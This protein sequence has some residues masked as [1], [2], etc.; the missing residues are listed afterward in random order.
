MVAGAQP[1]QYA[2]PEWVRRMIAG[3]TWWIG[4]GSPQESIWH[5]SVMSV[6]NQYDKQRNIQEYWAR[7]RNN[8]GRTG[9]VSP[10]WDSRVG[11]GI[12]G[13]AVARKKIDFFPDTTVVGPLTDTYHAGQRLF[14][15]DDRVRMVCNGS[16]W[17]CLAPL[18]GVQKSAIAAS[19]H[20]SVGRDGTAPGGTRIHIVSRN[21]QPLEASV[22]DCAP[23]RWHGNLGETAGLAGGGGAESR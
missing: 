7:R 22:R 9:L 6:F 17:E 3:G 12:A 15:R 10:A 18:G 8:V 23:S 2:Q 19:P 1:A 4:R 16:E 21:P 5:D 20:Q 11:S 14:G 13:G